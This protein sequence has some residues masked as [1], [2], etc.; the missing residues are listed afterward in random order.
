MSLFVGVHCKDSLVWFE[1]SGFCYTNSAGPSLELLLVTLPVALCCGN[2]AALGLQ[3]QSLH[4][5]QKIT[6]GI[7]VRVG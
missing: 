1:A 7:N 4:V 6:D 5:F 3:D 2:P